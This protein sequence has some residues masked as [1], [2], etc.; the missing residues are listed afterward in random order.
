LLMFGFLTGF[1]IDHYDVRLPLLAMLLAAATHSMIVFNVHQFEVHSLEFV[2]QVPVSFTRR[3]FPVFLTYLFLLLPECILL[4]RVYQPADHLAD[5][6]AI[7]LFGALWLTALHSMGYHSDTEKDR[8]QLVVFIFV[9]VCFFLLLFHWHWIILAA[10]CVL[11]L[12]GMKRWY[13]LFDRE[14]D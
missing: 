5:L 2:K 1:G 14:F 8:F 10:L 3:V 11:I 9:A 6:P 4:V 7:V 13:F 12:V